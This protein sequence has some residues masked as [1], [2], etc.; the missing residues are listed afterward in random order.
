MNNQVRTSN[1]LST[2]EEMNQGTVLGSLLI[3]KGG[4]SYVTSNQATMV[5]MAFRPQK[6]MKRSQIGASEIVAKKEKHL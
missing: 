3:D 2:Y 4:T 5:G 1:Y 6:T